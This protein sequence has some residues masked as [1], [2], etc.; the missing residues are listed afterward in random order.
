[1]L[2]CEAITWYRCILTFCVHPVTTIP[3]KLQVDDTGIYSSGTPT[4]WEAYFAEQEPAIPEIL[5]GCY[6]RFGSKVLTL[7]QKNSSVWIS[8]YNGLATSRTFLEWNT[9]A[10]PNIIKDLAGDYVCQN[11]HGISTQS[12]KLNIVGMW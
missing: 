3:P 7:M 4:R 6:S 2:Y 11:E 1:M 10:F 12:Y 8:E 5:P 9:S